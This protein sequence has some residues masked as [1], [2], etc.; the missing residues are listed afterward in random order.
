M[1]NETRAVKFWPRSPSNHLSEEVFELLSNS[2]LSLLTDVWMGS[3]GFDQ[4]IPDRLA[5]E[6][7]KPVVV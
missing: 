4:Y 3:H 6:V 5:G 1:S 7:G 2:F